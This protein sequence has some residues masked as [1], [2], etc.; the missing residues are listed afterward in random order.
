MKNEG[1]YIERVIHSKL[2]TGY[3]PN[4]SQILEKIHFFLPRVPK[5]T[6]KLFLDNHHHADDGEQEYKF[7]GFEVT[8][9]SSYCSTASQHQLN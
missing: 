1:R 2:K 4:V 6:V 8:L 7:E 3:W 9:K 5:V